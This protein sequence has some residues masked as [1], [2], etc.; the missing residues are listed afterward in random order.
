MLGVFLR[1]C[2]LVYARMWPILAV[3]MLVSA[4]L[5]R[6]WV[7][8]G[9]VQLGY[10]LSQEEARRADLRERLR[11]IEIE[12]ASENSPLR[13]EKRAAELGL[14]PPQANQI[15]SNDDAYWHISKEP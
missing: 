15:L 14:V 1:L 8:Q 12:W 5:W 13:L 7:H 2:T 3:A 9:T 4:A 6:V 10:Q 11:A